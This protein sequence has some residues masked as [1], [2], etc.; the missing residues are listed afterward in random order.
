MLPNAIYRLNVIPI[1][2]SKAFSHR[3]KAIHFTVCMETQKTL[4]SQNNLEKEE[5]SQS[6][7]QLSCVQTILQKWHKIRNIN[8]WN[9]LESPEINP[10]MYSQLIFDKGGKNIQQGKDSIFSNG[11]G[12]TTTMC[13]RM[14]LGHFLTRYTKI[15]S[16]WIKD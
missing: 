2:L 5:W 16:K 13:K 6:R 4:N 3:T 7:N 12:R 15:N 8:Q 1:K 14:K 11:D 10:H 9:K